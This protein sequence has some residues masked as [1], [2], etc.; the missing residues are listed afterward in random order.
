M[1]R[2]ASL[3]F[4][5]VILVSWV[6]LLPLA[7]FAQPASTPTTPVVP[8]QRAAPSFVTPSLSVPIPGVTI[9][10]PRAN[11]TEIVVPFL[12]QYINGAY[13]FSIT[14][15]MLAAIIMV[16]WGGFRYLAGA[17][18][19]SV[20]RGKE[21]IENALAGFAILL[22]SA[23]ILGTVSP[24]AVRVQELTVP[25]ISAEERELL[26]TRVAT[27]DDPVSPPSGPFAARR[28]CGGPTPD[29]PIPNLPPGNPNCGDQP[30]SQNQRFQ[31]FQAQAP[32]FLRS[33]T[34]QQRVIEAALLTARC[35]VMM[36]S[37]GTSAQL[38]Y[39]MAGLS[40]AR[41]D[42]YHLVNSLL[43]PTMCQ[44]SGCR[45]IPGCTRP[46]HADMQARVRDAVRTQQD[47]RAD[48]L[49]PGDYFSIF[50]GNDSC[51]GG[52]AVIFLNWENRERG[53]AN[54]VWGGWGQNVVQSH[55]CLKTACGNFQPIYKI[56]RTR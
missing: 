42:D 46:S 14:V 43:K 54:T 39:R 2:R 27:G 52:H 20:S 37:C 29:C 4:S 24:L 15:G 26:E 48:S 6:S 30:Q 51:P 50:N 16:M 3:L 36:G 21:I 5:Q 44:D 25:L 49:Q 56:K 22:G 17:T 12:M 10:A 18:V 1:L 47:A 41:E 38:I 28:Q 53:I 32:S 11:A 55:Y 8:A 35:G 9:T 7:A 13:R 23:A 33:Q 31:A 19:D 45:P 40:P 34:P